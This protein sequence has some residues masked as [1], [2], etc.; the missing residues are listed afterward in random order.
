MIIFDF[1]L[2]KWLNSFQALFS[3]KCVGCGFHLK[4][5]TENV[6]LPPCWRTFEDLSPYHY[7]CRPQSLC[8]FASIC[9]SFCAGK[10]RQTFLRRDTVCVRFSQNWQTIVRTA[11]RG[12]YK[13]D[14]IGARF[15]RGLQYAIRELNFDLPSPE[16]SQLLSC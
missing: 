13:W 2:Q 16:T 8:R 4:E 12:W 9:A 5:E 11:A 1:L 10:K 3:I 15:V 6:F 14:R 7:Q